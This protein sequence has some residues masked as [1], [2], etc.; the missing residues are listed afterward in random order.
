MDSN[1]K[2]HV[3]VCV[4][5]SEAVTFSSATPCNP[6]LRLWSSPE[7]SWEVYPEATPVELF[8]HRAGLGFPS[9]I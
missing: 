9:V 2:I 1:L 7:S 5:L 8:Q 4:A 3:S 6:I